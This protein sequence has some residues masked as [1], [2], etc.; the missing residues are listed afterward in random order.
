MKLREKLWQ[1][2]PKGAL[3]VF[4]AGTLLLL[5]VAI[6]WYPPWVQAAYRP[7][8][9]QPFAQLRGDDTVNVNTDGAERLALLPGIGEKKAQEIVRYRLVNGPFRTVEDL[10]FVSGIGPKTLE[11]IRLLVSFE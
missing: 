1:S 6:L 9:Q 2:G 3:F 10:G 8:S 5:A 11:N 4:F 7:A